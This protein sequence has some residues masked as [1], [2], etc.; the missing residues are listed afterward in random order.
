MHSR[1]F[2]V[3]VVAL[4]LTTMSWLIASK[5]LPSILVGDP[6]SYRTILDAQR[7]APPSAWAIDW[8]GH[9]L[10]WAI[11]RTKTPPGGLPEM[12][13]RVHFD[14]LP[15]ADVVPPQ[16]RPWVGSLDELR[17]QLATDLV[18][19]LILDPL[20]RVSRF[21]SVLK[22]QFL[23]DPIKVRGMIDGVNLYLQVHCGNFDMQ[24]NLTISPKMMLGDAL[25]PQTHLPGLRKG[26]SSTVELFSPLHPPNEPLEILQVKV[27][28]KEPIVHNGRPVDTW[29]VVYRNDPGSGGRNAGAVRGRMWVTRD[30]TVLK[31][32]VTVFRSVL[33]FTRLPDDEAAELA[34]KV[35]R[36]EGTAPTNLQGGN[37]LP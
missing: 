29:L 12:H 9:H 13:S 5:V 4:W 8:N 33:T 23:P 11:N 26:Q 32:E 35:A 21:E 30:G 20:G 17:G 18:S 14:Y 24:R 31:Q 25:S 3:A 15:L 2:N 1:W 28:G 19:E 10:G 16:L 34:G 6:P 22:F 37:Q 27:E 36:E 7:Q